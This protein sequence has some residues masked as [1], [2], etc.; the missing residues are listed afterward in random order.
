MPSHD[1]ATGR[2]IAQREDAL[3]EGLADAT[4]D[5]TRKMHL[6]YLATVLLLIHR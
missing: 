2:F 6:A 4:L 1:L 5:G 3:L